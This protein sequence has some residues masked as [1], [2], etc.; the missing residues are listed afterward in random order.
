MS[1]NIDPY[2]YS[3]LDEETEESLAAACERF[4]D[5]ENQAIN[6][7]R[8]VIEETG[9]SLFL[10]GKAGTGKTTFLR[11]LQDS[12]RKRM[13]VTAPTGIAA[14]NAGGVTLH[15]FFQLDFGIFIPGMKRND[16]GSKHQHAFRE[17]KLKI[18]RGMDLLIIDEVSM[19]RADLLDAVDAVLRKYRDRT[20]PFGGVQLLLIGDLQQLPPVVTDSERD[21]LRANYRSP[22]FFDSHALA[23]VNL[24]TI[25]LDKVYRQRDAHFLDLLNAIRSNSAD[26]QVLNALNERC[27]PGFNPSDDEGYIRLT[28]HNR[29]ADELNRKRLDALESVPYTFSATV[30]GK[31]PPSSYPVE[32]DMT[33]KV[34][35]QVM[36]VKN[37]SGA[38]RRFY[39]G[40][41]G[42]VTTLDE[43]S[44]GV[45]PIGMD[46]EIFVEPVQWE[47]VRFSVDNTTHE[48]KQVVDGTFTQLPLK[49]AWAITIHKSQ[50]LTFDRA[51]IDASLAFAHGQTYVALSRCRSLE[52][53]VLE[54]PLLPS[55]IISDRTV[56]DFMQSNAAVRATEQSLPAMKHDYTISLISELF[57]FNAL[58]AGLEGTVRILHENYSNIYPELVNKIAELQPVFRK[59]LSDVAAKFVYQATGLMP[60]GVEPSEQLQGRIH[61]ASRY[62][63]DRVNNLGAVV[64]SLPRTHDNTKVERK[65]LSRIEFLSTNIEL[66]QALLQAFSV[67]PFSIE[68]YLQIKAETLLQP[69]W[70]KR[71]RAVKNNVSTSDDFDLQ[72]YIKDKVDTRSRSK[73][74]EQYAAD[75]LYPSLYDKL[76]AWRRAVSDSLGVPRYMVMS[77]KRLLNIAN[78]IPKDEFDLLA[79]NGIG[80]ATIRDYGE[81]ILNII[82]EWL[83]ENPDPK[84]A[85]NDNGE[86][87]RKVTVTKDPTPSHQISYDM[88]REGKTPA[89]IAALR[90]LTENTILSHLLQQHGDDLTDD[91][92]LDWVHLDAA[93]GICRYLDSHEGQEVSVREVVEAVGG[94]CTNYDVRIIMR[95]R[96]HRLK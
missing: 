94:S 23:E 8:K 67:E 95:T 9:T 14:I 78:E 18:I 57:N 43:D 37:D 61:D 19:V 77:T 58:L 87:S 36:F 59:D 32:N 6:L 25:E 28:T 20:R 49:T 64:D 26:Q 45:T 12:C 5:E 56:T 54:R 24:V 42:R 96:G 48:I 62:F 30:D 40:M 86:A 81:D 10:T 80:P 74:G 21:L 39:N 82:N 92:I 44:V 22:Y 2:L 16:S 85:V 15:S 1:H 69:E 60:E 89:E 73:K 13:V 27:R 52:G 91:E 55:A 65:I 90:G 93:P 7:A 17:E 38:E 4:A 88:L 46:D 70:L 84:P 33:L 11:S 71:S 50:G 51:I 63:V 72:K 75:I 66:K 79:V 3:L 68:R 34:G 47:N 35:A 31:F 53:L 83:A 41:I 76:V 29:L